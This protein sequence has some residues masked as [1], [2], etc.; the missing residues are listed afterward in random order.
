[1]MARDQVQV[2]KEEAVGMY[3][4]AVL[5]AGSAE[6]L[7]KWMDKIASYIKECD[8]GK[9]IEITAT[10]FYNLYY[11]QNLY[12]KY[13]CYKS[14][15]KYQ[16]I[17]NI[18]PDNYIKIDDVDVKKMI[19]EWDLSRD[20]KL[21]ILNFISCPIKNKQMLINISSIKDDHKKIKDIV[22][23]FMYKFIKTNEFDK[24]F[25]ETLE[26]SKEFPTK[27]EYLDKIKRSWDISPISIYTYNSDNNEKSD[28]HSSIIV[29]DYLLNRGITFPT[30]VSQIFLSNS[31]Y[32]WKLLQSARW[33]GYNRNPNLKIYT[34]DS[35]INAYEEIRIIEKY[36]DTFDISY[37]FRK[38]Y[39]N[40]NF[41]ILNIPK[42]TKGIN[43]EK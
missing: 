23:N 27:K 35:I 18:S 38:W 4:V 31:K 22:S 14:S 17:N 10:P 26:N 40:Q 2:L 5:S 19:C 16:G 6:A 11:Y 13:Y 39:D 43:N 41:K 20:I 7:K 8:S 21:S 36:L 15:P 34:K 25:F 37:N 3:E 42:K 32:P 1:M 33:F 30:L 28:N 12:N 24:L 29:G 9:V